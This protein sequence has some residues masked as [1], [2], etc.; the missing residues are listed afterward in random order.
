L[1]E[2]LRNFKG[3]IPGIL[4]LLVGLPIIYLG[5]RRPKEKSEKEEKKKQEN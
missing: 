2:F 1:E 4:I 3:Y 5:T